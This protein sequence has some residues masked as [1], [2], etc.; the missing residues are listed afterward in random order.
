MMKT[1]KSSR[2]SSLKRVLEI[3]NSILSRK[4]GENVQL[5]DLS[6]GHDLMTI[7]GL[8]AH[9]WLCIDGERS[10]DQ[11]VEKVAK[12]REVLPG[13][14]ERLRHDCSRF[15]DELLDKKLVAEV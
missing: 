12:E 13:D 11:I 1:G 15:A 8:A 9:V 6:A 10:L 4:A 2:G 7:D 3:Q 14:L 5:I